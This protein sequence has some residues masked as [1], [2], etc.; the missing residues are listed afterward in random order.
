MSEPLLPVRVVID[1]ASLESYSRGRHCYKLV[2]YMS[3]IFVS[4]LMYF[5]IRGA[6]HTAPVERGLTAAGSFLACF[7]IFI[8]FASKWEAWPITF[9]F[10]LRGGTIAILIGVVLEIWA[11]SNLNPVGNVLFLPTMM[12]AVGLSEEAGKLA[13]VLFATAFTISDL[14]PTRT[15]S[16]LVRNPRFLAFLGVCVGFGFMM[17]ENIEYF[18][19][20]D[21]DD[22][23]GDE[24]QERVG[25]ILTALIRTL[26]NLHPVLTGLVTA[27]LA[28]RLST[29]G[30][31]DHSTHIGDWMHA[32][33]LP[34]LI[35]GGFDFAV[36]VMPQVVTDEAIATL[37]SLL[38]VL[39]TWV[40]TYQLLRR[41]YQTLPETLE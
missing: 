3:S 28:K 35:H 11:Q 34:A 20:V 37:G 7:G 2:C 36:S 13:A 10:C 17:T 16:T 27:R 12:L 18:A 39:G 5:G 40:L 4:A 22:S 15:C 41:E 38:I 23:S 32:L 9:M 26:L 1:S 14:N 29:P 6:S 30:R 21:L 8:W 19:L 33:W 31:I 24:M 25:R